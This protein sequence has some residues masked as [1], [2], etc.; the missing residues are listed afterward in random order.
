MAV[1]FFNIRSG[2]TRVAETEPQ[3]TAMWASSD[4]SPNITQGQDFG[5]RLA[6]EVVVEIKKLK[7]DPNQLVLVANRMGKPLEDVT[8]PD[9]LSYVSARITAENA[10]VATDEDYSDIYDNEIR[11]KL[12]EVEKEQA[13]TDTENGVAVTAPP[14]QES[15]ADLEKR[16]QL[17]ERLAAART[18]NSTPD[19]STTDTATTT[20]TEPET[21]TTTTVGKP[22]STT[23]TT[24]VK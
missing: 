20:T 19:T 10:P 5:W 3:I 9:V 4:R 18:A 21:T 7:Q 23:T 13:F 24:V 1:K 6:P 22:T 14:Q 12:A 2:E 17:E 11:R 8:E 15:L 16:V